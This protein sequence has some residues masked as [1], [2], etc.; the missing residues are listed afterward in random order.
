MTS[1]DQQ[2]LAGRA[3]LITGANRGLGLEI[4]HAFLRGGASLMLCA[5]EA[6]RLEAAGQALRAC[7]EGDQ[8]VHWRQ[9]DVSRRDEV[10]ALA[11]AAVARFPHLE[12]LVNNAGVYGP[13][14]PIEQ[15][16]WEAW[17]RA[18]EINLF[19]SV[20]PIRS[21]L[22]H[23]KR[24]RYGKIVQLSGGGATNPLARITAYAASKAAIVRFAESVAEE[25]AGMGIDINS[26]APGALNTGMLD[27][28]LSAGPDSVGSG[29]YERAL[30]QKEQGGIPLERGAELAVFL[31][32][33]ASDGIS[34]RLISAVWDDWAAWPA[35][36]DELRGS[37]VYTL[38]RITGRDRDKRWGDR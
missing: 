14:G 31:A 32:S 15:V 22:P 17:A 18:V 37:D 26:I 12:I 25:C 11:E 38:R 4:A 2:P 6:E 13:M 10:H 36:V 3:A 34:G 33:A 27:Q 28:V 21:L 16:D 29:F 35:H 7:C 5:R 20:L 24:R 9:A 1:P 19:G 30:Q 8:E 23:F